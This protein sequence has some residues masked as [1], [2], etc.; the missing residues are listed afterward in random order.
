MTTMTLN[1]SHITHDERL[2][3]T[4][5]SLYILTHTEHQTTTST[6]LLIFYCKP[7]YVSGEFYYW[8]ID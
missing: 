4:L 1:E 3:L 8:L 5:Y 2:V 7:Q 6:F